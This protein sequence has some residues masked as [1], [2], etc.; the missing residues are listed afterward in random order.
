MNE[1]YGY[2]EDMKTLFVFYQQILHN[3]KISFKGEPLSGL[4]LMGMLETRAIDFSTVIITSVNE[5]V[6]PKGKTDNS[7][8]PFDIKKHFKMPTYQ[9]KDAIFSY[10]FQR[11][12][13]RANDVYLVYNTETNS[14]GSGEKSRFLTRILFENQNIVP[15]VVGVK[16]KVNERKPLCIKKTPEL[17]NRLREIFEKEGIS[18]SALASYIYN[19]L[20]FYEQRVMRVKEQ[21]EIEEII[22]SNTMGSVVHGVLEDLYKPFEGKFLQENHLEE[23]EKKILSLL[24][25]YVEKYFPN[26][27]VLL[28]KNK[29]I[30]EV[31][32]HYVKRF[33]KQERQNL[34][35]G[36]LKMIA[37]EKEIERTLHI[38]GVDF[39]VKIRGIIDRIDEFDGKL[40][41]IDYKTG[42][43][44]QSDLN[45]SDF[46]TV[47]SQEKIKAMQILLYAYLY[48]E[49]TTETEVEAGIFSFKNLSA[50]LLR[51]GVG[52]GRAKQYGVNSE[53]IADF[54][55]SIKEIIAE[56]LNPDIPF[57]ENLN[58]P[59][60]V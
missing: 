30:F 46:E 5:G 58:D 27:N 33:L 57:V 20:T 47:I 2:L 12:L 9:E 38:E 23:M 29:L 44:Q 34:R 17:Q 25:K 10:H 18:A 4:Q 31:T 8:I 60:S 55:N 48:A 39:S 45:I 35:K 56:I 41:I 24:E 1:E 28:G 43:V 11:L 50:G 7:F 15:Y 36:K 37:T 22:A 49:N 16:N 32:E 53:N 51:I 40:R 6:L 19:P 59:F 42:K 21:T 14:Y 3:E 52:R 13:Q 54:M 26:R